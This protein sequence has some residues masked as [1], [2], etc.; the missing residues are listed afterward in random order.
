LAGCF[1]TGIETC[2]IFTLFPIWN[3]LT[4]L[5]KSKN[6]KTNLVLWWFL[7]KTPLQKGGKIS[8]FCFS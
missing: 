7:L 4:K 2:A 1:V 6:N 3:S 8:W 5:S